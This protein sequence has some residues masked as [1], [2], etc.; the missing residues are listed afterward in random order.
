MH[1]VAY[2]GITSNFGPPQD[3]KNRPPSCPILLENGA[4]LGPF[5]PGPPVA[6]GP[7][8]P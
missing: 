2:S 3:L 1:P 7:A 4:H 6:A 8:D 5:L